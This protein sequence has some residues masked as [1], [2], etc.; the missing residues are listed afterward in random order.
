MR[1]ATQD[2]PWNRERAVPLLALL[3]LRSSRSDDWLPQLFGS[4]QYLFVETKSTFLLCTSSCFCHRWTCD[5][6]WDKK[7]TQRH[8]EETSPHSRH[9]KRARSA[10]GGVSCQQLPQGSLR[11][12]CTDHGAMPKGSGTRT[13]NCWVTLI[14]S[15]KPY[16][17][18]RKCSA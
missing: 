14:A 6:R 17:R 7:E 9:C 11:P 12:N 18:N 1:T 15:Q 2:H 8:N 10:S 13:T 3:F 16:P 5:G 4:V